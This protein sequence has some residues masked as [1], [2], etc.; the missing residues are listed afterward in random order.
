MVFNTF[1]CLQVKEKIQEDMEPPVC[2]QNFTLK[3]KK[4]QRTKETTTKTTFKHVQ[5]NIHNR[6][7]GLVQCEKKT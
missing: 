4:N 6:H 1:V 7:S 5:V 2:Q 3:Q